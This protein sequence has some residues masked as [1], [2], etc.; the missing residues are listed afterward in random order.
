MN[1]KHIGIIVIIIGLILSGFVYTFKQQADYAAGQVLEETGTCIT[2]QGCL[3]EKNNN[4]FLL[5]MVLSVSTFILGVYLI[6]FDKTQQ[7]LAEHQVKVS[8]ALKEAKQKD[9]FGAFLAGF[10]EDEQKVIKAI[11]EQEGIQQATLRYR[12]DMSKTSLSLMLKNL[13]E[14]KIISRKPYKKTNQVF[15]VKKF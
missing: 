13:E 14:R 6:F 5:G 2:E 15:L 8:T 11:K 12:T 7:Q 4:L 10:K 3:H 9:E 1:Q